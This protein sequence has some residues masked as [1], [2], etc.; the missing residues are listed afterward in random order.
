VLSGDASG[1]GCAPASGNPYDYYGQID[2]ET[3]AFLQKV[4]DDTV[5]KFLGR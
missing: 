3:A 1:G 4:A 2:K 5:A